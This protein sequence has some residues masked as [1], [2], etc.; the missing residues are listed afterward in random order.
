[1][2]ADRAAVDAAWQK[3][4][5]RVRETAGK[6]PEQLHPNDPVAQALARRHLAALRALL[7]GDDDPPG[8]WSVNFPMCR[9]ER[10]RIRRDRGYLGQAGPPPRRPQ[11]AFGPFVRGAETRHGAADFRKLRP[12]ESSRP[13]DFCQPENFGAAFVR[14]GGRR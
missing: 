14:P 7:R 2:R 12:S 3:V 5:P 6:T 11:K 4:L 10:R 9:D 8:D 1:M 13:R